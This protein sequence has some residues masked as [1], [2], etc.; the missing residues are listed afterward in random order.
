MKH[1]IDQSVRHVPN[2]LSQQDQRNQDY[3]IAY[4]TMPL[5]DAQFLQITST[6]KASN[7]TFITPSLAY[8]SMYTGVTMEM[9]FRLG[10]IIG[11]YSI[12][13]TDQSSAKYFPRLPS[14]SSVQDWKKSNAIFDLKGKCNSYIF[15]KT[16][17]TNIGL[18]SQNGGAMRFIN[19]GRIIG[20]RPVLRMPEIR[21]K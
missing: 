17:A 6:L 19:S 10:T 1:L 5:P 11:L 15:N 3:K 20:A 12:G 21:L 9:K 18:G 7:E 13:V 2:I 14:V 8:A 16:V 4:R